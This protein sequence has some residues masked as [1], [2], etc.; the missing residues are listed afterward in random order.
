VRIGLAKVVRS[1]AVRQNDVTLRDEMVLAPMR[2]RVAAAAIDVSLAVTACATVGGA[3][4]SAVAAGSRLPSPVAGRLKGQTGR[5]WRSLEDRARDRKME[6]TAATR[7]AR[8]A[9]AL[10]LAVARRN[11]RS[12][13]A[14][15]MGLRRVEQRT[16]APLTLRSAL[17]GE[18]TS[19]AL[20]ELSVSAIGRASARSS[21]AVDAVRPQIRALQSELADDPAARD[22]AM[23]NLYRENNIN[24]FS[25]CGWGFLSL[26]LVHAV[27]VWLSPLHQ[28]IPDRVAGIV[29]V[30]G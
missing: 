20:Q 24:M 11:D 14:Y 4:F 23:T 25:P 6:R 9:P 8:S 28:S 22:E 29:A 16:G 10:A 13:G 21:A 3:V 1:R 27:P 18:V 2:L 30:V 7:I 15:A 26:V 19:R 17:I 12:P 5:F